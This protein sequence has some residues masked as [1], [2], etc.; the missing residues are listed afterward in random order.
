MNTKMTS[1]KAINYAIENCELPQEVKEKFVAMLAALDKK[2]TAV[3]KP[4][5]KQ[6]ANATLRDEIV[7]FINDHD[8]GVGFTVSELLKSC[9]SAE[10]DSNQHIS[11]LLRQAYIG[12]MISRGSIKRRTYFA[13]AGRYEMYKEAEEGEEA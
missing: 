7:A 11:A 3:R 10:G 13:P 5:T 2:A 6:Q 9:P 8:N 12:G 4:T 1:R